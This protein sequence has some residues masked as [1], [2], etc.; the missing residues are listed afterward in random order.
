MTWGEFK[1]HVE[2]DCCG[3]TDETPV[4]YIDVGALTFLRKH[5]GT[6]DARISSRGE[7]YVR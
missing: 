7:L 5:A 6:I 1:A 3:L 4:E 2:R